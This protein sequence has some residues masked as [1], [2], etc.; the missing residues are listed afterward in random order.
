MGTLNEYSNQIL[1]EFG[2]VLPD[3]LLSLED[4]RREFLRVLALKMQE[5]GIS[6]TD[7]TVFCKILDHDERAGLLPENLTPAFV[8]F[9]PAGANENARE[10]VEI[11]PL[12]D[13]ATYEGCHAMA[14]YGNPQGFRAA[15]DFWNYGTLYFYYDP[16]P[17]LEGYR[18]SDTIT[19]PPAFFT[20]LVKQAAF[21]SASTVK[22]KLAVLAPPEMTGR[23]DVILKVLASVEQTLMLQ[24]EQWQRE[25]KKFL[26]K[27]LNEQPHLRRSFSELQAAGY[28]DITKFDALSIG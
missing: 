12:E 2:S 14:F 23:M 13:V 1:Q 17:Q 6:D 9:V 26:N 16:I 4:C 7:K 18:G 15:W 22:L 25:F 21:N 5:L 20:L 28:N 8:E 19:F 24:L 11:I 10:K 27:D 3:T